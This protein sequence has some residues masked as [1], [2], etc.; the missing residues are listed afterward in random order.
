MMVG[1]SRGGSNSWLQTDTGWTLDYSQGR[2]GL[3]LWR[4]FNAN[5]KRSLVLTF[6]GPGLLGAGGEVE[7]WP[8]LH[9]KIFFPEV[10]KVGVHWQHFK[11]K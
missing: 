7:D 11:R 3:T 1:W 10:R 4:C 9:S 2:I 8:Q 5:V 6:T